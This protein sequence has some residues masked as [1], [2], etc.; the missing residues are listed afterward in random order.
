[1]IATEPDP[2]FPGTER[3][4]YVVVAIFLD[5]RKGEAKDESADKFFRGLSERLKEVEID[6]TKSMK[7]PDPVR[8]H[9]LLPNDPSAYWLYEGSL[10]TLVDRPNGGYVSWIVMKD[11][12]LLDGDV[13]D[14]YISRL[15]HEAKAPQVLDRRFVFFNSSSS[16]ASTSPTA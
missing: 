11:V 9:D 13:L 2:F 7:V 4:I 14:N 15:K 5:R 8:P 6:R 3:E 1:M 12:K 10:T 16:G